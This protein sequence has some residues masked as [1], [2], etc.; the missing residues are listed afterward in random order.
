[1][2]GALD[3]LVRRVR[4][5]LPTVEPVL[6][7]RWGQRAEDA[8]FRETHTEV[9]ARDPEPVVR[10]VPPGFSQE[11][12]RPP[13]GEGQRPADRVAQRQAAVAEP[14]ATI[15]GERVSP[16]A[17]SGLAPGPQPQPTP[18]SSAATPP[19]GANPH[20]LFRPGVP[21]PALAQRAPE[22]PPNRPAVS[23]GAALPQHRTDGAAAAAAARQPQPQDDSGLAQRRPETAPPLPPA[24]AVA[25]PARL[26]PAAAVQADARRNEE[27]PQIES[28]LPRQS[29]TEALAQRQVRPQM[30]SP[31]VHV[32]IGRVEVHPPPRAPDPVR[33]PAVTRPRISLEDYQRQRR[34]RGR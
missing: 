2:S 18:I 26:E 34:E 28:Q 19:A 12:P 32:T 30:H 15:G 24:P 1:M 33:A 8:G 20:R 21:E 13:M 7:S 23:L 11:T 16:R 14:Q 4:G 31:D 22:H 9:V 6:P 3:R 25:E 5:T 10:T 29:P 27:L 17:R